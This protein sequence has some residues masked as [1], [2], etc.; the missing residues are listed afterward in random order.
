MRW[1]AR[2]AST[3]SALLL[4]ACAS[5]PPDPPDETHS[6]D[7]VPSPPPEVRVQV[8]GPPVSAGFPVPWRVTRPH[9]E[10]DVRAPEAATR[11]RLREEGGVSEV[12]VARKRLEGAWSFVYGETVGMAIFAASGELT[13]QALGGD[14]V[15]L[16][17]RVLRAPGA[18]GTEPGRLQLRTAP[19]SSTPGPSAGPDPGDTRL[20]FRALFKWRSAGQVDLQVPAAG[21]DW[22]GEFGRDRYRLFRNVEEAIRFLERRERRR[23]EAPG[24]HRSD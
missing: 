6:G 21:E 2:L 20:R 8:S 22:P 18:T 7:R 24:L 10:L 23:S 15:S 11:E 4:L 12:E 13:L 14:K 1:P 17:F 19:D 16:T 3:T 5:S 9:L